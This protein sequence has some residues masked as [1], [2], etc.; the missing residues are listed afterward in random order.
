MLG[1]L[2][3][4]LSLQLHGTLPTSPTYASVSIHCSLEQSIYPLTG[5]K[6]GLEYAKWVGSVDIGCRWAYG[7]TRY[8]CILASSALS[9]G[10]KK[11]S[12]VLSLGT[13]KHDKLTQVYYS[14]LQ[15]ILV[16]HDMMICFFDTLEGFIFWWQHHTLATWGP[17]AWS[18]KVKISVVICC[19]SKRAQTYRWKNE[20]WCRMQTSSISSWFRM[21]T[22]MFVKSNWTS[23]GQTRLQ[24]HLSSLL[25][26]YSL[27]IYVDISY[28]MYTYCL[29][30]V[31]RCA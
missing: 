9:S 18:N 2:N 28:R 8:R 19:S 14:H 7:I 29:D 23:L 11:M 24:V 12:T 10:Y 25:H 16:Q 4:L 5:R 20:H 15:G 30:L 27:N 31:I 22:H 21:N 3:L 6:E 26:V 17:P 1:V 13:M